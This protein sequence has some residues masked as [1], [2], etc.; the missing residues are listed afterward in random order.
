MHRRVTIA[1]QLFLCAGA[2]R[3]PLNSET[4]LA[5]AN[6][7]PTSSA[8][9]GLSINQQVVDAAASTLGTFLFNLQTRTAVLKYDQRI[10]RRWA[11]QIEARLILS[12]EAKT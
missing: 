10:A 4:L 7:R 9:L 12:Q 1:Q 11:N 3:I 8:A 6:F 2:N 5:S